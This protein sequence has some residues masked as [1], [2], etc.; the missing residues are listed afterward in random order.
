MEL[1]EAEYSLQDY[2]AILKRRRWPILATFSLLAFL[3]LAVAVLLPAK[4]S[5]QATIL[6]EEQE[7]P[8]E[9]VISTITSFAAQQIQV[10]SQ[11]VLTADN[12]AG[13]ADKFGLFV[14]PTTNRRPP[15]TQMAEL[16]R[17]AMALELVSADVID[18][19]SGRPQEATIAFT[20]AFDHK[21]ANTAQK[22]TNELVTLFLD[23][24]LRNRTERVASTEAFL[25]LLYTSPSPRDQRGARMPSSA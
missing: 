4:Y 21:V 1:D 20:L 22:V 16:F 18:P 24:N 19:V 8:R 9:F 12:I 13:I 2:I 6:I 10:I 17:E 23:E 11:R 25:C 7:V 14:D 3:T 5:S 15:A